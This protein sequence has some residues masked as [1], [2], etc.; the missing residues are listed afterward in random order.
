[1]TA[2]YDCRDAFVATLLDLAAAD[3]RVVAVVND[4]VGSSKLGPFRKAFP[5]RLVN[6]GIAEQ[7]QVGIAA[8]LAGG[9]MVP[10]VSGASCF[11]TAR[12]MEQIKVDL[13][14]S[15]RHVVLCAQSP[16]VGYGELGPTHQSIEDLAWLRAIDGLTVVVPADPVET[17]SVLRWAA[18]NDGP[19]FVRVSR[20]PVPAIHAASYEF[21]PGKAATVREGADVTLVA[22]GIVLHRALAAAD[23]LAAEGVSVRV[24]SMASVKPLDLE[25]VVT[26]ALETGA[27]VTV[28]EALASGGLGGAV[29]ETVVAHHPVP[30]AMLGFSGFCTTGS[31][32]YLVDKAGMTPEGI[33]AAAR[34]VIARKA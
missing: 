33:A 3:P 32:E 6:V 1:M 14:Y 8:G 5:E 22:N 15:R 4:S 20:T 2:L 9:G 13:A 17:A 29:A 10:F 16:G 30:M 19:V 7:D 21:V 27:I 12:A 34:E 23:L 18:S 26:A 11:L 24:L 31:S 28:E 25:A